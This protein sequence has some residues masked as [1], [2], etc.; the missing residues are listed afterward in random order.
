MATVKK[1]GTK[2]CVTNSG[3]GAVIKRKGRRACYAKRSAAVKDAN[4]TKCRN[5]GGA[6]CKVRR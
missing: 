1:I 2:F 3:N 4:A 6:H 5:L